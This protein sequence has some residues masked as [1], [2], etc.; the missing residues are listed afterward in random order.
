MWVTQNTTFFSGCCRSHCLGIKKCRSLPTHQRS[1]SQGCPYVDKRSKLM[2]VK[3]NMNHPPVITIRIG[4][5]FMYVYHSQSWVV[6]DI[7]L[8]TLD[9]IS[10]IKVQVVKWSSMVIAK[11][12]SILIIRMSWEV[13]ALHAY[14]LA[15][16]L[17]SLRFF[18]GNLHA[19]PFS[20]VFLDT[21]TRS[22]HTLW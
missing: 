11:W 19:D 16:P 2:W 14:R 5:M 4:G 1:L 6:Y 18:G 7:V 9:H 22:K 20:Y 8:P 21:K 3:K 12:H 10:T 13:P 15:H 17:R